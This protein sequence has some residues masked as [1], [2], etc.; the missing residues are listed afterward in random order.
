[1]A[2]YRA[3]RHIAFETFG[4]EPTGE[5]IAAIEAVL[6]AKLPPQFLEFLRVANGVEHDYVFDV[7]I[8]G[9]VERLGVGR[10]LSTDPDASESFI[11]EILLERDVREI[12]PGVLPFATDGSSVL[13]LDLTAEGG[14]RVVVYVEGMPAWTGLNGESNYVEVA[15]SF[16]DFLSMLTID[17]DEL[18]EL[19]EKPTCTE[20]HREAM[21]EYLDIGMPDWRTDPRLSTLAS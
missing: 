12:P 16:D 21:R 11:E 18:L 1:M 17:L 2:S 4:E 15:A 10:T 8:D 19:L 13:Y 14:G 3:F 7:T 9:K 6:G 20:A 5:Q